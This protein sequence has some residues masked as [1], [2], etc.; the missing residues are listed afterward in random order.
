MF[1]DFNLYDFLMSTI[2]YTQEWSNTDSSDVRIR[3]HNT[4]LEVQ[5]S[6]KSS[7][8]SFHDSIPVKYSLSIYPVGF[9]A[10]GGKTVAILELSQ[11]FYGDCG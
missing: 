8:R 4:D 2:L 10:A 11:P 3:V 5:K 1:Y 7:P 9:T 6:F